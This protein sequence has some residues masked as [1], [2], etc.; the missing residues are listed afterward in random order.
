MTTSTSVATA[1][2]KR[3]KAKAKLDLADVRERLLDTERQLNETFVQRSE[4]I[5]VI[6]LGV[7]SGNNYMFIGDPGTAKTSVIDRF[8]MHVD[9]DRRFKIL[10]GKFTQPDDVFGSLDIAAFKQGRRKVV[11][12]GMLTETPFPILDETLKASDGCMNSLL[13]AL[14]PEREFK[15]EVTDIVCAG[16]ATNWPEVEQLSKHVE[17]LYDRFLLRCHVTAVDRS[18][19]ELRRRLYR[20]RKAVKRYAP[21]TMVTVD[22]LKAAAAHID[23]SVQISDAVIDL[24][25]D[26]VGRMM[27]GSAGNTTPVDVSDRR[28][29]AL[30]Q[31]L[32]AQAWLSGRDHVTVEDFDVLKHGLWSKRRDLETV[33]AVLDTI[34]ADVVN[35]CIQKAQNGRGIYR[36]LQQNGF[37]AA[38]VNEAVD[39]IVAIAEDV[40]AKLSEPI[41]TRAGRAKVKKAMGALQ[42]DFEDLYARAQQHAGGG[43]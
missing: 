17:A 16:G 40:K 13:G 29:T 42:K 26:V 39:E 37:G 11:T 24:L 14:G 12:D 32:Q 35:D 22:E 15:G 6:L 1:P 28:S 3:R 9:T 2:R 20:A 18:D 38:K 27:G 41:F 10:M 43:R 5:R 19:K 21:R 31:V 30:Q 4:A 36:T 23:D 25:D 33:R 8:T 34:D 7:L